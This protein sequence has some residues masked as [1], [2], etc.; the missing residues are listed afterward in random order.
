MMVAIVAALAADL[1]PPLT[2]LPLSPPQP[3]R[4][5]RWPALDATFAS[6]ADLAAAAA[7]AAATAARARVRG[8]GGGGD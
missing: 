8:R 5:R 2:P 1:P 7:L 3:G 6:S 4:P